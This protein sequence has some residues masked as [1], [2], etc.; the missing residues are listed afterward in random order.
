[1]KERT[2]V[3]SYPTFIELIS[4]TISGDNRGE[5]LEFPKAIQAKLSNRLTAV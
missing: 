2:K 5:G 3:P 1:M 4:S